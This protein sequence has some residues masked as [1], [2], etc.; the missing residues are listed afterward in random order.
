VRAVG[1]NDRGR[2]HCLQKWNDDRRRSR[3]RRN[4]ELRFHPA[5]D[6]AAHSDERDRSPE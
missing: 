4:S 2:W 5:P 6:D 1:K 3:L